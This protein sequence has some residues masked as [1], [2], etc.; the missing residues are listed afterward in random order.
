MSR[1]YE[2]TVEV[3][4]FEVDRVTQIDAA[5]SEI[6]FEDIGHLNKDDTPGDL[7]HSTQEL[8]LHC[9]ETEEHFADCVSRAVW[10]AN[11]KYCELD[12]EAAIVTTISEH[13]APTWDKYAALCPELCAAA[14]AGI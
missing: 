8:N 3:R 13:Y 2:M 12:I 9:G 4:G 6:G 5:L 14:P 1:P 7:I 11:G 10:L